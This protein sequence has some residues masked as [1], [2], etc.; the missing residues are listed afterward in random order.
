MVQSNALSQQL[1]LCPDE[2]T[3]NEEII[4]LPEEM[5]VNLFDTDLQERIVILDDLDGNAAEALKLLLKKA[6]TAMAAGLDDW[7]LKK[8]NGRNILFY[9]ERTTYPRTWI[10]NEIL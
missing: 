9:K 1:D 3:D 5:F 8:R 4:M 6:P 2:D 7:E 10:Y